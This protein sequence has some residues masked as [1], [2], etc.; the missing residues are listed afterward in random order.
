[1]MERKE[2]KAKRRILRQ[3]DKMP[4]T[5]QTPAKNPAKT[6]FTIATPSCCSCFQYPMLVTELS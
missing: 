3:P 2:K 6:L 4:T 5:K 1:M